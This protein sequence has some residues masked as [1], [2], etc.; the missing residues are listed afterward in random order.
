M[1][2]LRTSAGKEEIARSMA[3]A[4]CSGGIGQRSVGR[5][6]GC[7]LRVISSFVGVMEWNTFSGTKMVIM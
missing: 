7:A 3:E 1:G 5:L 4:S 6:L 2:C